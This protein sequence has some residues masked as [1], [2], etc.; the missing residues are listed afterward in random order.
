LTNIRPM[1]QTVAGVSLST[2]G[3]RFHTGSLAGVMRRA[4]FLGVADRTFRA[5]RLP[6]RISS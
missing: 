3:V 1:P 6:L 2:A 5:L 4:A